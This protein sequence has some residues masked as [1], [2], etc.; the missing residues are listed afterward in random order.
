MFHLSKYTKFNWYL[1]IPS[2]LYCL[3]TVSKGKNTPYIPRFIAAGI[4]EI[5]G[6]GGSVKTR[7]FL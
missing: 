1:K 7:M 5:T 6:G 4:L 3:E 2:G